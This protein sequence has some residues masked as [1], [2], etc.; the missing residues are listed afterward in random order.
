MKITDFD[1]KINKENVL[2]LIDCHPDSPVY[3]A[4]LK[5]YEE[6]FEKACKML[7]RQPFSCLEIWQSVGCRDMREKIQ[8]ACFVWKLSVEKSVVLYQN[9]LSKGSM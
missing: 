6:V 1:I 4:V 9:F 5:E 3:D 2:R 7:F 8:K